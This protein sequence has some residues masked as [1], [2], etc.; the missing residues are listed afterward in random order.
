[1]GLRSRCQAEAE[2]LL[3]AVHGV[4]VRGSSRRRCPVRRRLQGDLEGGGRHLPSGQPPGRATRRILPSE[5]T[6]GAQEQASVF[7]E[8]SGLLCSRYSLT[9]CSARS[10]PGS[11][12]AS[13]SRMIPFAIA[14]YLVGAPGSPRRRSCRSSARARGPS[15]RARPRAS[16]RG[17]AVRRSGSGRAEQ[18]GTGASPLNVRRL[19]Q[20]ERDGA[21]ERGPARTRMPGQCPRTQAVKSPPG[22]P[23]AGTPHASARARWRSASPAS[24]ISVAVRKQAASARDGGCTSRTRS[25]LEARGL[26][27]RGRL[28]IEVLGASSRRESYSSR[29]ASTDTAGPAPPPA[30]R[31][32][33][34]ARQRLTMKPSPTAAPRMATSGTT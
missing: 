25:F 34:R 29:A 33:P 3:E 18:L 11:S 30:P 19:A 5:D 17:A 6:A 22:S 31:R 4:S 24:W 9:S 20:Q 26:R 8:A 1:M 32:A 15:T 2:R 23:A 7:S 27:V 21:D 10:R 14:R 13:I 12:P 16:A 28:L